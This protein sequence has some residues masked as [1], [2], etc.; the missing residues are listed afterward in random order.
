MAKSDEDK[1]RRQEITDV[2][3]ATDVGATEP[4]ATEISRRAPAVEA[5]PRT[6]TRN[7]LETLRARLQRKFH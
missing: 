7:G 2:E 6:L 1:K 4:P 5:R 3:P